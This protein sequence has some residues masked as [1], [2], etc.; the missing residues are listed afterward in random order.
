MRPAGAQFT[1]FTS[2]KVQI[3]AQ[4]ARFVAH[5]TDIDGAF[6][7]SEIDPELLRGFLEGVFWNGNY[8]TFVCMPFGTA[9]GL[10]L[11]DR[12]DRIL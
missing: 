3:L 8:Y 2:T 10:W 11:W 5:N 12:A 9:C 6:Y 4:K 1:C 7:R